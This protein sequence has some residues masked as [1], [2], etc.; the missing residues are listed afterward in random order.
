MYA[1]R[2]V[3]SDLAAHLWRDHAKVYP[4]LRQPGGDWVVDQEHYINRLVAYA[5]VKG[6][7]GHA[8]A[9]V[10]AELE[11]LNTTLH[12]LNELDSKAHAPV[13][14]ED[15]R[16]AAIATYVV[17][18]EIV[19]RTDMQPVDDA[20]ASSDPVPADAPAAGDQLQ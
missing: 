2:S 9:V 7:T 15:A 17:V 20:S 18:G 12:K 8:R 13:T 10:Q 16:L 1:C 11:R 6:V 4:P 5:P 3:L 19:L 14:R